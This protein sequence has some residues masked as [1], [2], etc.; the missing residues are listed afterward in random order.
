[1]DILQKFDFDD[2][3][4]VEKLRGVGQ[5]ITNVG[6]KA[7]EM[8]KEV[9]KAV[10]D[11][12][13]KS[14]DLDSAFDKIGKRISGVATIAKGLAGAAS[15]AF[16][17]ATAGALKLAQENDRLVNQ[18]EGL[19]KQWQ[20]LRS[21]LAERLA[22]AIF[23][24]Q[25]VMGELLSGAAQGVNNLSSGFAVN[26]GAAIIGVGKTAKVFFGE[27]DKR[28]K[29]LN[30]QFQLTQE[31]ARQVLNP[32]REQSPQIIALK[33][34]VKAVKDQT[35]DLGKTYNTAF[36][37]ARTEL[38]KLVNDGFFNLKN[39]NQ[40]EIK[41]IQKLREAY[42]KLSQEIVN[43]LDK[44]EI[45]NAEGL[46]RIALENDFTREQINLLEEKARAAAKAAGLQ[47]DLEDE[48]RDLREQAEIASLKKIAEFQKKQAEERLKQLKKD[49]KERFDV[50]F[51]ELDKFQKKVS[52]ATRKRDIE[53]VAET[54]RITQARIAQLAA[55]QDI[56]VF[57]RFKNRLLSSLGINE[58]EANFILGTIGSVLGQLQ[59]AFTA[60]IDA[61][62]EANAEL[63]Q[64]I[65]DRTNTVQQELQRELD[66]Q[67]QGRENNV[68][69][70]QREL[71]ELKR[72][73]QEAEIER[74]KLR[75]KQLR[76]QLLA[77]AAAQASALATSA[78]NF[79]QASSKIPIVGIGLA[80]AAITTMFSLI[81][82]FRAQAKQVAKPERLYKGGSLKKTSGFVNRLSGRSDVP[83]RGRGHRIE[84]SNVVVGGKE[85]IVAEGPANRQT[86]R[87]WDNMNA[88]KY[89][90]LNLVEVLDKRPSAKEITNQ[91]RERETKIVALRAKET[92]T[93]TKDIVKEIMKEHSQDL[94]N[95]FNKEFPHYLTINDDTKQVQKIQGKSKDVIKF[96]PT[97]SKTGS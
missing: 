86:D 65:R 26:L 91:F 84:D 92:Q 17:A 78:A 9:E 32:F 38:T 93:L 60:G 18:Q 49:F 87:F 83:G 28:L 61:Q 58:E 77:D 42:A 5:E 8:N 89:D 55:K 54:V 48:F 21:E 41:R 72:Q 10:N 44:A 68:A 25:K 40:E 34:A 73:E 4:G 70:K 67:A 33:A 14:Q 27:M 88:G 63:L 29:L 69:S 6:E 12:V 66:L 95:Y 56:S 82:K 71:E 39:A 79:F 59:E 35:T 85:M 64:S 90:H 76:A 2:R 97:S 37:E 36:T 50:E 19:K 51:D 7:K 13:S 96:D 46:E 62:L 80:I 81:A 16:G 74:E 52:D 20:D 22:P 24:V 57:D 53:D 15:I 11:S 75:K 23:A 30:L 31:R 94:I 47:F 43:K 45:S 1:M 3:P